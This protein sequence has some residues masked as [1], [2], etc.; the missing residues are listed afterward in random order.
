MLL[1]KPAF[2]SKPPFAKQSQSAPGPP[3]LYFPGQSRVSG[4]STSPCELLA[5]A[6]VFAHVHPTPDPEV[7]EAGALTTHLLRPSLGPEPVSKKRHDD[8]GQRGL[9]KRSN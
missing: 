9:W 1:F 5:T 3:L 6:L 4:L 2:Q 8:T 7:S